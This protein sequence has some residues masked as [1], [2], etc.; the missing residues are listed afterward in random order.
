MNIIHIIV[1]KG[2]AYVE[3]KPIGIKLIIT[4]YD[5]DLD[6]DLDIYEENIAVMDGIRIEKNENNKM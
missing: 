3:E 6:G 2:V 5:N 1:R 4:D